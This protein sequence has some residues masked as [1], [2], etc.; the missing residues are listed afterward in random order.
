MRTAFARTGAHDLEALLRDFDV[1]ALHAGSGV[2]CIQED[3]TGQDRREQSR[4]H[5]ASRYEYECVRYT[6]GRRKRPQPE[7]RQRVTHVGV[8]Y[9][10]CTSTVHSILLCRLLE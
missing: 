10:Y 3:R 1:L 7:G 6:A 5:E 9:R 8:G 4:A 2:E